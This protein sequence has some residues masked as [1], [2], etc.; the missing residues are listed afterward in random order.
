MGNLCPCMNGKEKKALERPQLNGKEKEALE[1]PQL[2]IP[3]PQISNAQRNPQTVP[4]P[5]EPKLSKKPETK[6]GYGHPLM[7]LEPRILMYVLCQL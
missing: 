6:V 1:R 3:E 2:K 4:V 5:V 7:N